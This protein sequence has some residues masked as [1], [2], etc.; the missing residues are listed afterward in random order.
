M[1]QYAFFLQSEN[2]RLMSNPSVPSHILAWIASYTPK[3]ELLT[4]KG[5]IDRK[6]IQLETPG[7]VDKQSLKRTVRLRHLPCRHKYHNLFL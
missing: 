3:L 7:F 1:Q 2:A 5:S 4:N 6:P